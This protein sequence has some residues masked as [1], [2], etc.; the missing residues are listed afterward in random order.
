M[1]T[2]PP[3]GDEHTNVASGVAQAT[4][5]RGCLLASQGEQRYFL[6]KLSVTIID[7]DNFGRL[8]SFIRLSDNCVSQTI[9]A[10][11]SHA[12]VAVNQHLV[13]GSPFELSAELIIVVDDF[14]EF[15]LIL[16]EQ[17]SIQKILWHSQGSLVI[18]GQI[19]TGQV[20]VHSPSHLNLCF[21]V[22]TVDNHIIDMGFDFQAGFTA[23]IYDKQM[24]FCRDFKVVQEM[25]SHIQ[26]FF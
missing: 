9:F 21:S 4:P 6:P 1:P 3:V 2:T 18:G 5:R 22:A 8:L 10:S 7:I 19:E 12:I 13:D 26:L 25:F 11:L 20:A 16:R 14:A 24:I 23:G 17:R 15:C